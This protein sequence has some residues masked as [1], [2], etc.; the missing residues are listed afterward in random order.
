MTYRCN[1]PFKVINERVVSENPSM[2]DFNYT[3]SFI[4][5]KMAYVQAYNEMH[6]YLRNNFLDTLNNPETESW[7]KKS[8]ITEFVFAARKCWPKYESINGLGV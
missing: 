3:E 6:H 5:K 1:Y 8:L 4:T 2:M 7:L